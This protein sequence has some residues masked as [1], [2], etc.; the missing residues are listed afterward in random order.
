MK[1]KVITKTNANSNLMIL[2]RPRNLNSLT[3]SI[4]KTTNAATIKSI[5][6]NTDVNALQKTKITKSNCK[7]IMTRQKQQIQETKKHRSII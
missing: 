6:K 2:V 4:E 3:S 1:K 7:K 5:K